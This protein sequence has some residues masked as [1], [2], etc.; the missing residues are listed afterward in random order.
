MRFALYKG[1]GLISTTIR[2]ITRGDYSH[3]A[4]VLHD[5][6]TY[7]AW[8]SGF[9]KV[10][11]IGS[12][13]TPGTPVD[14]FAYSVPLTPIEERKAELWLE[15]QIGRPYDYRDVFSFIAGTT[16]RDAADRHLFC[17]ES[18]VLLGQSIG[19][20]LFN[21]CEAWQVSPGWIPRSLALAFIET[22]TTQ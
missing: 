21:R 11:T 4:M 17:S 16:G 14:L 5:G 8:A 1:T 20:P 15:A 22:T 13:H 19:R 10:P 12:Q 3:V 6:T 9:S 2:R 18:A 7:E